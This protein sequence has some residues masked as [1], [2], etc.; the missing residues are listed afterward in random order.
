MVMIFLSMA[1]IGLIS[2][3]HGLLRPEAVRALE[4]SDWIVHAGDVGRPEVLDALRRIAPVVAVR[5]NVDRG[6]WA[7]KL[8]TIA[9]AGPNGDIYV[10]HDI[11]DL[12]MDPA[13]AGIRAI[14]SGHSHKPS[15]IER[16]G[17]L[18]LN[19]GAAGPRRFR[20][21]VTVARLDNVLWTV[22][23][24]ELLAIR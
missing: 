3:T 24:V 19:P 18:Y 9:R 22:E 13:A 4:G 11:H 2:D 17:V 12:D 10:L 1:Q 23:F 15:R 5:G 8:P 14:V 21:P 16:D 20:L 7:E 6:E